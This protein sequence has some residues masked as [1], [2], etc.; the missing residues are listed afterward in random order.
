MSNDRPISYMALDEG[1]PVLAS[2]GEEVG[3]V[4]DVVADENSDIFAGLR[5]RSGIFGTEHFV[6]AEQVESITEEAV[7]LT[8]SSDE[9]HDLSSDQ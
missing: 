5:F 6:A 1:T 7:T 3:K 8:I 4:T 2:N 9:A